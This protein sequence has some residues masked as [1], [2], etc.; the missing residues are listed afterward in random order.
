[1][2]FICHPYCLEHYKEEMNRKYTCPFCNKQY[3]FYGDDFG[4]LS[5][6]VVRGWCDDCDEGC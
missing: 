3:P 6:E 5:L 1:M 2:I 4:G